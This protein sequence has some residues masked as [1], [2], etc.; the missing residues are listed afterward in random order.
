[1]IPFWSTPI[2]F[3]PIRWM[4]AGNSCPETGTDLRFCEG[5]VVALGAKVNSKKKKHA[6]QFWMII[7]NGDDS[8][9]GSCDP[10]ILDWKDRVVSLFFT[11]S[12]TTMVI[13]PLLQPLSCTIMSMRFVAESRLY[14]AW[15]QDSGACD[16]IRDGWLMT[17]WPPL[18]SALPPGCLALESHN[19]F[20]FYLLGSFILFCK[21]PI[22]LFIGDWA[23]IQEI[24]GGES[25]R[26][27]RRGGRERSLS[28]ISFVTVV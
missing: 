28:F 2:L 14:K 16:E 23:K 7:E 21:V 20:L 11:T 8:I 5:L 4:G 24:I 12:L 15:I 6:L 9:D 3:S 22:L 25:R 1:M 26:E 13:V 17:L 10:M 19:C 27:W 18:Y